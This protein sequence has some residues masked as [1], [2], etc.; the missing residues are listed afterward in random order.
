MLIYITTGAAVF[1][2]WIFTRYSGQ[3]R[4]EMEKQTVQYWVDCIQ[5][6]VVNNKMQI[7]LLV[8]WYSGGLESERIRLKD[9]VTVRATELTCEDIISFQE[10]VLYIYY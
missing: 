2:S 5:D 4:R 1:R 3:L 6:I 8:H 9:T 7:G 10:D